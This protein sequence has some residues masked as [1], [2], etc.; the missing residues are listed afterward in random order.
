MPMAAR[1][2]LLRLARSM[3]LLDD[4]AMAPPQGQRAPRL[5][6][7][8]DRYPRSMILTS[9]MPV[10]HWHEIRDPTADSI[11]ASFCTAP[12]ART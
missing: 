10:A 6:V 11:S 2:M 3:L 7:C 4:F 5:R 8:D 9:Q 12:T 1:R